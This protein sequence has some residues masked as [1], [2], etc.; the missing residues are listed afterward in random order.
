MVA[1]G[2]HESEARRTLFDVDLEQQ[3]VMDQIEWFDQQA[4]KMGSG[5]VNPPGF[6]L[7]AIREGWEVPPGFEGSRKRRLRMEL[8]RERNN[9]PNAVA[10]ACREL[11]RM[12]LEEQYQVWIR[13]QVDE[14]IASG[15]TQPQIDKRIGQL[16]KEIL[17]RHPGLYNSVRQG[18]QD[19]PALAEHAQRLFRHEVQSGMDLMSF[20]VFVENAQAS[21]F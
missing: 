19:C 6:L 10:E 20:A 15:Y 3:N 18:L 1:R 9:G 7:M 13:G 5:M 16:K 14:A 4:R 11:K 8:E 17:A 21:L 2:I 12:E